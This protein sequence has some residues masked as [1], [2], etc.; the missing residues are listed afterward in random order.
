MPFWRVLLTEHEV[1]PVEDLV[2]RAE[3]GL[4]LP[5]SEQLYPPFGFSLADCRRF[6]VTNPCR[7]IHSMLSMHHTALT[8]KDF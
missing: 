4:P 1:L 7:A 3:R 6:Q 5:D 8:D 2:L